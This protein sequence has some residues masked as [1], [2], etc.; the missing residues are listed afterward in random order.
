MSLESISAVVIKVVGSLFILR[1][2]LLFV[3]DCLTLT[4]LSQPSVLL[5]QL[6]QVTLL[7]F[8][9]GGFE[10]AYKRAANKAQNITAA[11]QQ[12][13]HM[14]T[15]TASDYEPLAAQRPLQRVLAYLYN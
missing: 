11:M 14:C 9:L 5:L 7:L 8:N 6:Q 3:S 2:R 10:T 12:V 13:K 15:N 4:L 1:N